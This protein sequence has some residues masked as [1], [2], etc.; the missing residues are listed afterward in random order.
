[1]SNLLSVKVSSKPIPVVLREALSNSNTSLA[2]LF[3]TDKDTVIKHISPPSPQV[4]RGKRDYRPNRRLSP[5]ERAQ[6]AKQYQLGMSA[7]ELARQ[8]GINRHTVTKHLRS[9]GVIL[10]GGQTKMTPDATEK[11]AQLYASGQSLSQ[12]GAHLGVDATTVHKAL[13]KAGVKMR[14]THSREC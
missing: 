9:D 12:I 14:D 4:S 8:Y 6:L 5:A 1:L 11:A 10:R 13:K 7:L 2:T 3:R